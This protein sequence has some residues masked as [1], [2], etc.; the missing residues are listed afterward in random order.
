MIETLEQVLADERGELA[1]L[2]RNGLGTEADN[3]ERILDRVARA[4][5]DFLVWLSEDDAILRAGHQRAWFRRRFTE[6]A[7]QGHAR[8]RRG[9]REYRRL[10]VPQRAHVS[11]AQEA[12]REEARRLATLERAS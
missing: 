4:A 2:R 10:L 11:A 12:A 6:W 3:R 5:E 7:G 1:V 9:Q 8:L